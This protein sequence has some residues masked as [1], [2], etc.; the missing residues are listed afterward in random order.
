LSEKVSSVRAI[1][2]AADRTE[3]DRSTARESTTRQIE[4]RPRRR[5]VTGSMAPHGHGARRRR[6]RKGQGGL[7]NDANYS[8][9][10][11]GWSGWGEAD[12]TSP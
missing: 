11:L 10:M 4:R 9:L 3:R 5:G 1:T 7:G 2:S 6:E 12:W 8:M